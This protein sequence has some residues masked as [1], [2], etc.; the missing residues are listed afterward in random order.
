[1]VDSDPH[2]NDSR[3]MTTGPDLA[4]LIRQHKGTRS[5]EDLAR[6]GGR[7]IGRGR[8]HQL[9]TEALKA[10]PK[11]ATI[12]G[13]ARA[14]TLPVSEVVLACARSLGVPVPAGYG[15][16]T[17][18]LGGVGH[19]PDSTREVIA[20][21]AR[22][23]IRLVEHQQEHHEPPTTHA[24]VSPAIESDPPVSVTVE[25][26]EIAD[27]PRAASPRPRRGTRGSSHP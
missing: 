26:P 25:A 23:F 14:L 5:Y 13:V 24:G 21:V 20:D 3:P 8:Y 10:F 19:L 18:T 7:I 27:K 17:M 15:P 6:D 22:E 2:T 4:S 1:M 16:D 11:P 9:E 12:E